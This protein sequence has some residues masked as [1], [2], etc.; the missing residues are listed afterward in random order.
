VTLNNLGILYRSTKDYQKAL[1]YLSSALEVARNLST[2]VINRAGTHLNICAIKSSLNQ[3][4]QALQHALTAIQMLSMKKSEVSPTLVVAYHSAGIEYQHLSLPLK[5]RAHFEYG[6]NISAQKLGKSH[7]LTLSLEEALQDYYGYKAK[8]RQ[9]STDAFLEKRKVEKPDLLK[10]FKDSKALPKYVPPI[11][12]IYKQEL[13]IKNKP[14]VSFLSPVK[15]RKRVFKRQELSTRVRDM[16]VESRLRDESLEKFRQEHFEDL[17]KQAETHE[18]VRPDSDLE[19]M[20]HKFREDI[21]ESCEESSFRNDLIRIAKTAVD[22]QNSFKFE[23]EENRESFSSPCK[24]KF[25]E[26]NRGEEKDEEKDEEKI[27]LKEEVF[28]EGHFDEKSLDKEPNDEK[29]LDYQEDS[30]DDI[31]EKTPEDVSFDQEKLKQVETTLQNLEKKVQAFSEDHK[32]L[33]LEPKGTLRNDLLTFSKT[34]R[35]NQSIIIQK[36]VKSWLQRKKFL[37]IRENVVK[38][39]KAWREHRYRL[40]LKKTKNLK[41]DFSQQLN[42]SMLVVLPVL[43]HFEGQTDPPKRPENKIETKSVQMIKPFNRYKSFHRTIIFIQAHLRGFLAR[44]RKRKMLKMIVK[45]Q[46]SVRMFQIRKIYLDILH[47]IIF[48][49]RMFRRYRDKKKRERER[50]RRYSKTK[51][52]KAY[53]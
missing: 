47:A 4:E 35:E 39:Q 30:F 16:I 51:V 38:I 3:H 20:I 22:H 50:F 15:V 5:A 14:E 29:S 31:S 24:S 17:R 40:Y 48:I 11:E 19:G 52:K 25:T 18:E 43:S 13:N 6:F 53:K 7:Q 34:N 36:N 10:D 37:K 46:S 42:P 45:M 28:D 33:L 2:D 32:K 21:V 12:K 26:K 23:R 44:L 49:Q 41:T 9:K 8:T 1:Q 27:N